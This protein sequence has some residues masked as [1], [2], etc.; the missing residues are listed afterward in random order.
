MWHYIMLSKKTAVYEIPNNKNNCK[1]QT[2]PLQAQER[3]E[4]LKQSSVT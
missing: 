3:N 1:S 4:A 2:S